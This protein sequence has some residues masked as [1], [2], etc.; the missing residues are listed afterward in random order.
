[1][2]NKKIWMFSLLLILTF[3]F[4]QTAAA[5]NEAVNIT[6]IGFNQAD[7]ISAIEVLSEKYVK[8]LPPTYNV[9]Y[10]YIYA[11]DDSWGP[12]QE[13]LDFVSFSGDI[14]H[15]DIVVFDMIFVN[16]VISDE[17]KTA[18]VANPNLKLIQIQANEQNV[19][20]IFDVQ[21][22][23]ELIYFVTVPY[24]HF[25]P[26]DPKD[27]EGWIEYYKGEGLSD[28][29]IEEE[30]IGSEKVEGRDLSHLMIS[31]LL[32][33]YAPADKISGMNFDRTKILYVGYDIGEQGSRYS[34]IFGFNF[35][36]Q[37]LEK[38][39]YSRYFE[40]ESVSYGSTPDGTVF[41]YPLTGGWY[42]VSN[43]RTNMSSQNISFEEYDIVI[44]DGFFDNNM[45]LDFKPIF[46]EVD[47]A[48]AKIVFY[49][50]YKNETQKETTFSKTGLDNYPDS[51][52]L[53]DFGG[54]LPLNTNPTAI[55][56]MFRAY[57][58]LNKYGTDLTKDMRVPVNAY[59]TIPSGNIFHPA[60]GQYFK[61][62]DEYM[63]WHQYSVY[64]HP[65]K[66]YIGIFG[67]SS[68]YGPQMKELT[69]ILE[70]KGYN[71]VVGG[72]DAVGVYDDMTGSFLDA[73][74]DCYVTCL[75]SMKNWAMN[76]GNQQ[77]GVYQLEQLNVPV[78][79][80][81]GSQGWGATTG[82]DANSGIPAST[83]TWMAAS[84]NVD[85]MIDFIGYNDENKEW[86]ADRAIAW[87]ELNNTT[88]ADKKIVFMYY[89]YPPGKEEIGANY[90]NVMR[91]FA[92]DGAKARV[93][94]GNSTVP[95]TEP[96]YQGILREL[97]TDGYDVRTGKLPFVT[98]GKGGEYQFDY[99]VSDEKLI[100]NEE[101]LIN[102]IYAQGINVGGYAP[103]VL[104]KMVQ[105]RVDF[106]ASGGD[107]DDWWG[108][109]LIPVSDYLE[110]LEHETTP[111][112]EGGNG[113]MDPKL[114]DSLVK[115]WGTPT[116]FG[117]IPGNN[118]SDAAW[119]G[120]I[121]NDKDNK[122]GGGADRNYIVVPMVKFGGVRMMPEPNRALASDKALDSATYH[123]GDLPP[124]HQYVATYFWLNRGTG[125]STG[126]GTTGFYNDEDWKADAVVHFG[127]HGTQ[128]WL[129]GT[130]VGLYRTHDWGP[131]LLP[132][133]PNIYPY[134][135]ANVGEGLTAEYRGN[136]VIISHLTPPMVKTR[137][138]DNIIDMETAIR[139]YQKQVSSGMTDTAI[140]GAYRQIII[141]DVYA[142]G[143]NDAFPEQFS[144]YKKEI[145]A[146]KYRGG[147]I[148]KVTAA[149]IKSVT[150]K[151]V[152]DY[153]VA[154]KDG[155]FDLFLEN[156]LHN[157]VESIKENSLSY[158]TH[159]YGTFNTEQL[160]PMVWNMWSR[161]GFDDV[162]LDTYFDDVTSIPTTNKGL[163]YPNGTAIP[164]DDINSKYTEDDVLELVEKMM[165]YGTTTPTAD[166][167]RAD[168]KT[169]FDKETGTADEIKA[170][171]DKIIYFLLG[172]AGYISDT[173]NYATAEDV[174]TAWENTY[175][176]NHNM[177]TLLKGELFEFYFYFS[178]P[179]RLAT[180][181]SNKGTYQDTNGVYLNDVEM[182]KAMVQFVT[183]VRDNGTVSYETVEKALSKNFMSAD[184]KTIDVGRPWNNDRMTYMMLANNRIDYGNAL[185]SCG[186]SE[187]NALKN[188]LSAGYIAPS[189]GNDP[190]LNPNVLPTGRNFYGID[191]STYSTPAAW[192]VG[193]AMGE[194][195][196]I[197]YYQKYGEFPKTVSFMRFGVD[198]IQDEGTLEACLFYLLGCEPTWNAQGVFTGA[199]PVVVGDSNYDQMFKLT[200]KDGK[201]NTITVD[202]SRVDVVYNSAGMRDG[203]GSMLRYIDRAVKD[204]AKLDDSADRPTVKNNV[205]INVEDLIKILEK[206]GLSRA[207][208]EKLAT[209]RVFAQELGNYEIGTGN[210]V[211]ASGNLD[212]KSPTYQDDLKSITDLY[213]AKMG[214]LYTEDNWGESSEAITKLLQTL[215]GR[216]DASIFA[217]AGNLYDSVDND[218][219]YQY[220]GIMNMASS[221]YDKDGNYIK[222]MKQW[223]VPQEY[224]ADT[225][226]IHNYK[227]GDKIV[228]TATEYIEKDISSRLL[229]PEWIKGQK[230]AGYSGAMM[231]AEYIEN[232]Y[233]W[234]VASN[235]ELIGQSTWDRVFEAFANDPEMVEWMSTTSP[236]A[237]QSVTARM[238]EASRT[239]YWD[240]NNEQM[241]QLMETYVKDVIEHGV[242]CCHH[243]CG[244]P[245][246]DKFIAGQ[247]S[248]LGLT[249]DEEKAYWDAVKEATERDKPSAN[250][251]PSTSSGGGFGTAAVSSGPSESSDSGE[252]PSDGTDVGGGYGTDGTTPG[253]PGAPVS[254]YEMTT[255]I[256][257][258]ANSVRDFMAN[259]TFSSSSIFAIAIV[260]IIIGAMFYGYRKKNI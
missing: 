83:F 20:D 44:F 11:Y 218:D 160:S 175:V 236:Y 105:Q 173:A 196:L 98:I 22:D 126:A 129:P 100:L 252:T 211:S 235:G 40:M 115:T 153:L 167:I 47:T 85:G 111:I 223:K 130:S 138:Y 246:L 8:N 56:N 210:L 156:Q 23:S 80:V 118:A 88:N 249:P 89:N 125:D 26:F 71:V 222:D 186:D 42:S 61:T 229:N 144:A 159:T 70:D 225:S 220:F 212:P 27:W 41:I 131:V 204:V 58:Q 185:E 188:A 67:F 239:G 143:W 19:G 171:E 17:L 34:G 161:Q 18:K 199:K 124:T 258:A 93:T 224:I 154:N 194:Q 197:D 86:I 90:L 135:V 64:Y 181:D 1:M 15:Q 260:V 240:A 104:D 107:P 164:S 45:L 166:Q 132:E 209:A 157:F 250:S 106:I 2:V 29:E 149:D 92:G 255:S 99:T 233:G 60:A 37:N 170:K 24:Y 158:G 13:L 133:I 257:N 21:E 187:M 208:A 148:S 146:E 78:I 7:S 254:G 66:P 95:I 12:S 72:G 91:S 184:G 113:T 74:D 69:K 94:A 169:V 5:S 174:V 165:A 219:V 141:E 128:E 247:M 195:L 30:I 121:W 251:Q 140:L 231:M 25:T 108:C 54:N 226:N 163:T 214:Y 63:A 6:Y 228:Y 215:L 52:V 101:N 110:W 134:I 242:A 59:L 178:V 168:L 238:I 241:Q 122:I 207:E 62:M 137:L 109:E 49:N 237:L 48:G 123:S 119:G 112:S 28:E 244:N 259:P 96:V 151:D 217:S 183:D 14:V 216:T 114:Y 46:D 4:F 75:I 191:P 127:T 147:N 145:A 103:G 203:Y 33:T 120:M 172:P 230:E 206:A 253:T 10:N 256:Q 213:L 51:A 53:Y 142:L 136:A 248:V 139:G 243:S 57:L 232:L 102:L 221:M 227:D 234:S 43:L 81:I 177:Y 198:F 117:S 192:R 65:G 205:K 73:N 68:V 179:D 50:R 32:K 35:Q 82:Y 39:F 150:D 9:N 193:Q 97:R 79:K 55:K 201:G 36:K 176:D 84:S 38:T 152:S 189:S 200:F 162:L 16:D 202:R 182:R 116:A 76:Y 3:V 180:D 190:V 87:A 31:H 245:S 155:V 77:E